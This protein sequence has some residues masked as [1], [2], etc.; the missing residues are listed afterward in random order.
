MPVRPTRRTVL[1]S[2]GVLAASA[3]LPGLRTDSARAA[4]PVAA[5]PEAPLI[6][7]P[8]Q[9]TPASGEFLFDSRS[10]LVVDSVHQAAL[11]QAAATLSDDLLVTTGIRYSPVQAASPA[12]GDVFLTLGS[13]DAQ[14]GTEGYL[15]TIG[16]SL[17]IQA[18]TATGAFFG[19]RTFLQFLRRS[20]HLPAGT[21][22]DWPKYKERGFLIS[23][24]PV[25]VP[26]SFWQHQIRELSYLK[27]NMIWFAVGYPNAPLAQ[28]QQVAE[29]ARRYH[30]TA[31]PMFGVPSHMDYDLPNRP[32]L[33]VPGRPTDLHIGKDAAYTWTRDKIAPLVPGIPSP[34]WH[35]AADEFLAGSDV[36]EWDRNF[37]AYARA[38]YGADASSFDTFSGFINHVRGLVQPQG[39]RLRMWNDTYLTWRNVPV[40][41]DVVIEH[42]VHW[43]RPA[44]QLIADGYELQNCHLDYT[45]YDNWAGGHQLDAAKIY[46]QFRLGQFDGSPALP[47]DHPKITGSKLHVWLAFSG[48]DSW[49]TITDKLYAPERS[50]AQLLWGSPRT[51]GTYAAFAPIVDAVG[52]APGNVAAPPSTPT[53]RSAVTASAD[54][55]LF[56]VSTDN[57]VITTS[58]ANGAWR[59]WS[60]LANGYGTGKARANA[61]VAEFGG[62]LF[63]TAQDGRVLWTY[64]DA[65]I[66]SNGGWHDW[67]SIA[68]G[69]YDGKSGPNAVVSAS[70]V[71]AEVPQLFTIA[72]DG[73]VMSTFHQPSTIP[74]NGG[75]NGW[76]DIA[77]G[78]FDGKTAANASVATAG[79][80][81]YTVAPDGHV[82]ST[83]WLASNPTNG[84]WA[85]WFAIPTGHA[86]GKVAA[87]TAITVAAVNGH[88]QL[89]AIAPDRQVISTFWSADM[90]TNGGWHEWFAIPTGHANGVVAPNTRVVATT[91]N[92][93][94]QLFAIASDRHVM[95]T[96]WSADIPA[97]G[98]WHEWFAIPTGYHDGLVAPNAWISASVVGSKPT[99]TTATDDNRVGTTSWTEGGANGGWSAWATIQGGYNDGRLRA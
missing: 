33:Q 75:W 66:P 71:N 83:F 38:H 25:N 48:N 30:L 92:G 44:Q 81:I 54:A 57:N 53:I 15:M 68:G 88:T 76:F 22:R 86:D 1:A 91:T 50:L 49:Q 90:P 97:N 77:G 98:G 7:A 93:K 5:A 41:R 89:F 96:F 39:K 74:T 27:L 64:F 21:I 82:M 20:A 47:D 18:R 40:E 42:W 59:P 99:L 46:E 65:A 87:N 37:L 78:F 95:S 8:Q 85:N 73:H 70:F 6:P 12:P 60:A 4:V 16:S 79:S 80:Q 72:P 3:A 9:W 23:N 36:P 17:R 24:A 13:T 29:Y 14:L 34:W 62:R 69:F 45:Y 28:M 2:T 56:A 43:G 58:F 11:A 32:D 84:G 31:V 10:R 55:K 52:K 67:M 19:T 35:T 51:A 26:L 63:T 94:P 61:A